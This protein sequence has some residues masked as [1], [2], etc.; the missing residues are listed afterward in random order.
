MTLQAEAK[1]VLP[2]YEQCCVAILD[3]LRSPFGAR[4]KLD[5]D[6]KSLVLFPPHPLLQQHLP[7][8]SRIEEYNIH[9]QI[10]VAKSLAAALTQLS[11]ERLHQLA[12][13]LA[14]YTNDWPK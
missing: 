10:D 11:V 12:N 9:W 13:E 5:S 14:E 3:K 4:I 1:L 8:N 2:H 6:D 7:D